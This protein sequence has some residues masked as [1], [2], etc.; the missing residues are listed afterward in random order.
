VLASIFWLLSLLISIP[1]HAIQAKYNKNKASAKNHLLDTIKYSFDLF[2]A[3]HDA[4]VINKL[5]KVEMH[6]I[7]IGMGGLVSAFI[8]SYQIIKVS[9]QTR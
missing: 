2:P 3:S 8:S 6:P 4:R 5:F 7:L 1:V 9:S